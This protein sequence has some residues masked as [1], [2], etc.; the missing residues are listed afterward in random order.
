MTSSSVV[1]LGDGAGLGPDSSVAA[2]D[3]EADDNRM[4]L[5]SDSSENLPA[6]E[7][8]VVKKAQR[9]SKNGGGGT[10]EAPANEAN[11]VPYSGGAQDAAGRHGISTAHKGHRRRRHARGRVQLKKG[12]CWTDDWNDCASTSVQILQL[13]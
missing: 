8:R 3:L 5:S 10:A 7:K 11:G 12:S 6:K 4:L 2:A 1:E 9:T 13:N